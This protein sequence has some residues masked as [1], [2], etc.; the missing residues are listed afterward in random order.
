MQIF[1]YV[2]NIL[3]VLVINILFITNIY[4][5]S[6]VPRD[7]LVYRSAVSLYELN[8]L[9][10]D[11]NFIMSASSHDTIIFK[12]FSDIIIS[13]SLSVSYNNILLYELELTRKDQVW[14]QKPTTYTD[15][16]EQLGTIGMD[17]PSPWISDNIKSSAMAVKT[18]YQENDWG[19]N[20]P[21]KIFLDIMGSTI[22]VKIEIILSG[23]P[24]IKYLKLPGIGIVISDYEDNKGLKFDPE[25]PLHAGTKS[26]ILNEWYEL[27]NPDNIPWYYILPSSV[28]LKLAAH[29]GF[30]GDSLGSGP[31]ENTEPSIKAALPYTKIIEAD[32]MIT[33]DKKV[34]VS[35]DYNLQ[36][37]TDYSGSDPDNTFI[38]NLDYNQIKDLHLRKRNY[39][40]D[41]NFKLVQ[42]S[43]LIGYIMTNNTILTID[44]KEISKR[45]N[46]IN[47]ECTAACNVTRE[48][49]AEAWVELLSKI[50]SVVK[51]MNAWKYVAIK[52]PYSINR[53]K[54]SLPEEQY[55]D[56]KKVLFFPVYYSNRTADKIVLDINDWYNNAPN[57]LMAIETHFK[58]PGDVMLNPYKEYENILHYVISKT[59]LR[60]GLYSEEPGGPKGIVERYAQWRFKDLSQDFRGDPYWLMDNVPY[61]SKAVVTTDRPDIWKEIK[62]IYE[63][64]NMYSSVSSINTPNDPQKNDITEIVDVSD[65]KKIKAIYKDGRININEL[66]NN[67]IGG[68]IF[69]YDLQGQLIVQNKVIMVPQMIISKILPPGIYVLRLHGNRQA[70]IKLIVKS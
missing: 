39:E 15:P 45:L 4:S 38:Y 65:I 37:L 18:W 61:F 50:L 53:I 46:P 11:I 49:Q 43:D 35:H 63:P 14:T 42:L 25:H 1:S 41:T 21:N 54:E 70:V 66:N 62:S 69:L 48:I 51:D 7:T 34:V 67:D 19:V 27:K 17:Y 24:T 8:K 30:W 64:T 32:V 12:I 10:A 26:P 28:G 56:M 68:D 33:H 22:P 40:I 58:K 57:Y 60:P 47:N 36:R 9:N 3:I 16:L 52:T 13:E 44:I 59:G 29:R 23:G 2:K 55:I 5:L 20:N 31:I 6:A